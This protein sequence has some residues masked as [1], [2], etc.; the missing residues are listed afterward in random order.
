MAQVVF[1]ARARDLQVGSGVGHC[2]MAFFSEGLALVV[3]F[4]GSPH[5]RK[6]LFE[7]LLG[8]VHQ[9]IEFPT[10]FGQHNLIFGDD[11]LSGGLDEAVGPPGCSTIQRRCF[12]LQNFVLSVEARN[13]F[14]SFAGILAGED[15]IFKFLDRLLMGRAVAVNLLR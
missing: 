4:S 13:L 1:V 11:I 9:F 15:L 10:E 2:Q 12:V 3:Q 8:L 5:D 6:I 14:F 7:G